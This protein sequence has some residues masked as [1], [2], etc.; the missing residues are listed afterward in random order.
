MALD[1]LLGIKTEL[2]TT[3]VDVVTLLGQA[4]HELSHL[5]WEKL[6]PALCS[7]KTVTASTKYLCGNDLV[8]QIRN[9]KETNRIGNVVSLSKHS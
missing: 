3:N 1:K 6:R 2:I 8:K 4:A 7:S 5:R 9:A